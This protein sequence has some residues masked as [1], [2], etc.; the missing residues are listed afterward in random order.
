[1]TVP[2]PPVPPGQDPNNPDNIKARYGFVGSMANAVPELNGI[3]QQATREQWTTDRFLMAVAGTDW[4]KKN[5]A[6][7]REWV[8]LEQTDPATATARKNAL[9]GDIQA[10]GLALGLQMNSSQI[11]QSFYAIQFSGGMSQ[12]NIDDYLGR[13]FFDPA[14]YNWNSTQGKVA[15]NV[16]GLS[17]LVEDYGMG[18]SGKQWATDQITKIMRGEQTVQ[19]AQVSAIQYAASKY[20]PYA[21]RIRAGESVKQIAQPYMDTMTQLLEQPVSAGVNDPMIQ[22]ALQNVGPNG[23]P[24]VL[25]TYQFA[26]QLRQDPRWGSTNNAKDAAAQF[27]LKVGKD[28]G[29][30]GAG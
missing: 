10:R 2:A 13:N 7:V 9:M 11:E 20:S 25:P 28:N 30:L 1:M 6:A 27:I 17:T 29:F 18:D 22:K 23:Q 8:T 19:G 3:L 15:E 24:S 26:T 5:G 16:A 21:D 12:E 4:Y 14:T